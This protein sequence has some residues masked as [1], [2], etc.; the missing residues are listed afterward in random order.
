LLQEADA[1]DKKQLERLVEVLETLREHMEFTSQIFDS[2]EDIASLKQK[3]K[4]IREAYDEVKSAEDINT[5]VLQYVLDYV[6]ATFLKKVATRVDGFFVQDDEGKKSY[7]KKE[8][9]NGWIQILV[10]F[11]K[12][13]VTKLIIVSRLLELDFWLNFMESLLYIPRLIYFHN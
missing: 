5:V 2:N 8:L 1:E 9:N 13:S 12:G 7:V 6:N 11:Q 10:S 4:A 3:F